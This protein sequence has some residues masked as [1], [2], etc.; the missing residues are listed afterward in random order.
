[1]INELIQKVINKKVESIIKNKGLTIG[2]GMN[3]FTE[4]K[5]LVSIPWDVLNRHTYILG[6]TG[7]GKTTLLRNL[8]YQAIKA[9][10]GVLF[11]DMK[12]G[13]GAKEAIKDMWLGCIETDK[14]NSFVYISPVEIIE[15]LKSATWN[16]CLRGDA[17]VVA[18]KIFDALKNISMN[19]Q[20][21]EDVKFDVLLKLVSA[22][23]KTKKPF[24]LK[25]L[26]N[27]LTSQEE[28]SK[29]I[30]TIPH[31]EER[32]ALLNMFFEWEQNKMQFVKNIKGT[33]VSLQ[34]LST[35]YP[36]RILETINPS[37]D[38]LEAIEK[39]KV[40]FMLLPTLLAKESMQQIAKM[41]LSELKTVAG[42]LLIQGK[43]AKFLVIV[44]EFEEMI[45]SSVRDLF[46]KAREAG[47]N[48][49]VSHQTIADIEVEASESFARSII[50]NTATK[51]FMQMKSSKS[52][53]MAANI[54]GKYRKIP[55]LSRWIDMEYIIP[56]EIFMGSNEMYDM[57][58]KVGEAIVKID[59]NIYRVTIPYPEKRN[60]I[61]IGVDIPYPN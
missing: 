1:M 53:E 44:D 31:S 27:A 54:V 58:L 11:I 5:Q 4:K 10:Y 39:Q 59:A 55:F 50:D 33:L 40:V 42:E 19:A 51:I 8:A 3:I 13:E 32:Q 45:F 22:A 2:Y 9:G 36:A 56:P 24:T 34:M 15:G 29:F 52:A 48:M 28:L 46:N 12:G 61:R 26:A 17:T 16:P 37:F 43:R 57:G 6:S 49:I 38:L 25:T 35:S 23:K 30:D 20:F 14:R 60:K 41:L 18:N 7:S 47:I 21:Y